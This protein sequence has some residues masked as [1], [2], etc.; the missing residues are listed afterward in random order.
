MK[1]NHGSK[2]YGKNIT[3]A[4]HSEFDEYEYYSVQIKY[5]HVSG[6]V[7]GYVNELIAEA[8]DVFQMPFYDVYSRN[9]V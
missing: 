1:Y 7:S 3:F 2:E 9:K 4:R 6:G 5:G 8:I